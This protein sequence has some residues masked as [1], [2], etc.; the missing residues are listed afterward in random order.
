MAYKALYLCYFGLRE[1]LVQT[2]VLPYLR[3]LRKDGVEIVI[4]TF[5]PGWP[6][7]WGEGEGE[8]WR[9][10]LSS[11]G[12]EWEALKYHK[13]PAV[14][15]TLWDILAGV[16][17]ILR[18][19]PKV[20]HARGHIPL[21]MA[22]IGAGMTGSR[23]IFDIRGLLADEYVDAGIMRVGG[24][25]YRGLKWIERRGMQRADQLVVLTGRMKDW[26]I[27][28]GLTDESRIEVIPCCV[29][30]GKFNAAGLMG[31]DLIYTGSVTGLYL[32]DDMGRFF[33]AW[34]KSNPKSRF[35]I[36]TG[37]PVSEVRG[38]LTRLGIESEDLIIGRV[39]P[40][41]I[42]GHLKLAGAG[43]S[44][45]KATF[46]Q[47]AASPTKVPEYLAAGLPVVANRGVGDTDK[48][49]ENHGV[50]VIIDDLTGDGLDSAAGKLA[51]LMQDPELAGR[52]R[53]VARD[54]FDLETVGGARYR[55][56]YRRILPADF[57]PPKN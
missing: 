56:V 52:C 30:I 14:P 6:A 13:R 25:A 49:L 43:L 7:S 11:E 57:L 21:A 10:R 34:K 29:D 26:L 37:W 9:S 15:A 3:E 33:L 53:R 51:G 4:L 36:L 16:R 24:T 12:I 19:R 40:A 20:L 5:E 1:P 50:G 28:Q 41:E 42:P 32:L 17:T 47:I 31:A 54:Y 23:V 2:Q 38:R 46:S 44:F 8:G 45:R 48:I 55:E 22:L 35:R 39:E 18:T 27:E